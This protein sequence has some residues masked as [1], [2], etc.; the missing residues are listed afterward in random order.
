MFTKL[1]G[2]KSVS[3]ELEDLGKVLTAMAQFLEN[4]RSYLNPAY[5]HD[6]L[7]PLFEPSLL[8]DN[9]V[10]KYPIELNLWLWL[11]WLGR[12][13]GGIRNAPKILV[14]LYFF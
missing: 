12:L 1:Q 14:G 10:K 7:R 2:L 5:F 9:P 11:E 3:S 8:T 4:L 13:Q 6:M